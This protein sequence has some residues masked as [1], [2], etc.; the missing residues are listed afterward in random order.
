MTFR[1]GDKKPPLDV[2]DEKQHARNVG[3]MRAN[4]W[5]KRGDDGGASMRNDNAAFGRQ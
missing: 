1:G 2:V 3:G 4:A 5:K